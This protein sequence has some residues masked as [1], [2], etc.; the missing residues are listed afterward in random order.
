MSWRD[1]FLLFRLMTL[2]TYLSLVVS[3]RLSE[4]RPTETVFSGGRGEV[5]LSGLLS[6]TRSPLHH[7]RRTMNTHQESGSS[8]S[9]SYG[10]R[11]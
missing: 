11:A 5:S 1:Q 2:E 6:S 9:A 8:C 10:Q 4:S 3:V 7:H